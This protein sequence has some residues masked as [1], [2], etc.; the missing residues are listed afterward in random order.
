MEP[1]SPESETP[2]NATEAPETE[3]QTETVTESPDESLL[4]DKVVEDLPVDESTSEAEPEVVSD[5]AVQLQL[6]A[7]QYEEI[8]AEAAAVR[9]KLGGIED[10]QE[11]Q[12]MIAQYAALEA[13]VAD[14]QAKATQ[15]QTPATPEPVTVQCYNCQTLLTI[16]DTTRPLMIACPNCSA[17]SLQES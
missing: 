9:E 13:T 3:V 2:E 1:E 17:E 6:I 11:K 12:A 16:V 10:E 8:T 15:L 14:L 4:T 7:Q 5:V